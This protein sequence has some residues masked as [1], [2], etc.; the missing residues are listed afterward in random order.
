MCGFVGILKF[1]NTAG[2]SPETLRKMTRRLAHR[3]PDDEGFY[4]KGPI[5]LGFRRLSILDL[6]EAGRQP[7]ANEDRSV[8][9]MCNGEIYNFAALRGELERLGHV[10]RSRSDSEVIV[11]GYEEWGEQVLE[12]L[13]GMFALAIWDERAQRLLLAR[14][15]FGIK[16]LHY[17]MIGS[18]VV[19]GSE[20]KALLLHPGVSREMDEGALWNYLTFAQVPAPQTIYKAIRKLLPAHK[21]VADVARKA[22]T[23]H[24]YYELPVQRSRRG[25]LED[26]AAEYRFHLERA[27]KSH[28]VADVPVGCFLSGGIDS[29]LLASLASRH[30]SG[31]L[32]TFSVEFPEHGQIDEGNFQRLVAA[33]I[34]SEHTAVPAEP[35]FLARVLDILRST[36]EPFAISSFVPLYILAQV[37]RNKVKVILSGDGADELFAGYGPR[38][39]ADHKRLW[40]GRVLRAL[41]SPPLDDQ[42][43]HNRC[44]RQR[45]WRRARA[46]G[47]SEAERYI[48][49]YNWFWNDEKRVL[50]QREILQAAE[51]GGYGQWIAQA[52][53]YGI[54]DELA[55][56]LRYEFLVPLPDEMLT[57]LDRATSAW[58]MEGRVPYLDKTAA[59]FAWSIA[60]V[61]HWQQ[62]HGKRVLCLAA[63]GLVPEPVLRRKKGG[64]TVPLT[65]WVRENRCNVK[66]F[67]LEP[68]PIFDKVVRPQAVRA[69]VAAHDSRS[70]EHGERLWV[71][72]VLKHWMHMEH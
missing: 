23:V 6:S 57:K 53:D 10:F 19:F 30:V 9:M 70:G 61:L 18:G 34:G 31:R 37:A 4:E 7:M 64:F 33:Q 71:L 2:V 51:M 54:R 50:L 72:F 12:H 36:D 60:P 69:M 39:I 17:A 56:K 32:K 62:G 11:H 29:S 66:T 65:S 49:S 3:G 5:A 26:I 28:L 40:L 38:Y 13:D 42:I 48:S 58:G 27:V 44:W 67:L 22:I 8:W 15:R 25:T 1:N 63:E 68:S 47:L 20:I 41:H 14:D 52:Y 35:D 45:L 55:R 46:A 16:P 21:M 59:E 24:R 43:W